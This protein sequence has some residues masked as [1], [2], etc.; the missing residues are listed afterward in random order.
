MPLLFARNRDVTVGYVRRRRRFLAQLLKP[1]HE[2]P[3]MADNYARS[4]AEFTGLS[5]EKIKQSRPFKN[6]IDKLRG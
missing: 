6:Y 1:E 5:V 3:E 2:V 4:M